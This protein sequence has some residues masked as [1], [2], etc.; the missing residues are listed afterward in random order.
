MLNARHF[1]AIFERF[2]A[3]KNCY[4][5][6]SITKNIVSIICV[7]NSMPVVDR[8]VTFKCSQFYSIY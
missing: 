6:L 8:E 2:T 5:G 4:L 3:K 1:K 7:Y